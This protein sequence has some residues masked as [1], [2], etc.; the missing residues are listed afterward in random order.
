MNIKTRIQTL[1]GKAELSPEVKPAIKHIWNRE[2]M[3]VIKKEVLAFFR[4]FPGR[5]DM[6]PPIPPDEL[7][8]QEEGAFWLSNHSRIQVEIGVSCNDDLLED[9]IFTYPE[10]SSLSAMLKKYPRVRY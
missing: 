9:E 3:E 6:E 7:S 2:Q 1:E 8:L 4:I 10:L 5:N